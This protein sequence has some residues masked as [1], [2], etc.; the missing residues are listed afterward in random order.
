M[1]EDPQ[2]KKRR[3]YL[4]QNGRPSLVKG[5]PHERAAAK[6][7]SYHARGMTWRQMGAQTGMP[8]T[9][10]VSAAR[11]HRVAMQRRTIEAVAVLKFEEPDPFA[12]VD[13]T[14]ARRRL[15]AL[16]AA[17]YTIPF[18]VG[19]PDLEPG[20]AVRR[21]RH[22][23]SIIHGDKGGHWLYYRTVKAIR[24]TYDDLAER[25][26]AE[27]GIPVR[28]SRF[29]QTF[30]AKLDCAPPHCWDADS[31]D[32]PLAAPDWTGFCAT[33]FGWLI[34]ERDGI[35][36]C[37]FCRYAKRRFVLDGAELRRLRQKKG[38]SMPGL[39]SLAG[40]KVDALRSWEV[41]RTQPRYMDQLDLVLDVLDV[42]YEEVAAL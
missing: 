27:F 18:M 42:S 22:F 39:A 6:I 32:D 15:R 2:E 33:R 13:P 10:F 8:A 21:R 26:P 29:A 20:Q 34:H 4:L 16:W 3:K 11:L 7:R 35:P 36:V 5:A 25:D 17:G 38:L 1:A 9:T 23:Q 40:V 24:V 28:S 37:R 30:A 19:Y 31:I 12:H 41:G 14:G